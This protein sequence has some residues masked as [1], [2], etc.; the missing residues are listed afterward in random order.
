MK[1]FIGNRPLFEKVVLKNHQKPLVF[2]EFSPGED[3]FWW[4]KTT[5]NSPG[6]AGFGDGLGRGWWCFF[7]GFKRKTTKNLAVESASRERRN[8]PAEG[9]GFE[10]GF[11]WSKRWGRG[12]WSE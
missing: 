4:L 10:G 3:G 7:G 8:K 2:G 5:K 1:F 11:G 12:R 9:M 6:G